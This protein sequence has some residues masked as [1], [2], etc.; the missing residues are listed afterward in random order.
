M[1]WRKGKKWSGEVWRGMRVV[2]EE[3]FSVEVG[4]GEGKEK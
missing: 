2:E 3:H 4:R 1:E